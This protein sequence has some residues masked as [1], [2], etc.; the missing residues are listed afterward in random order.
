MLDGL[1]ARLVE[2]GLHA[3][4]LR[5]EESDAREPGAWLDLEVDGTSRR[6][7]VE[8]KSRW[9]RDLDAHLDRMVDDETVAPWI[10]VLPRLDATR[11]A[12]LRERGINHADTTGVIYLRLPGLFIHVDGG[13]RRHWGTFASQKRAV[14]P[15]SKK[16]S[17]V[18]RRF[19]ESPDDSHSVT[20]L[21]RETGI[22]IGWAWDVTE[23]L[24]QRGYIVGTGEHL[25]LADA[26]SALV[27]WCNAYSWTKSKRRSF[28][29]PHLSHEFEE[30][31][32]SAWAPSSLQWALTLLS[33]A[34]RRVGHVINDTVT[35]LYAL[36][37][38]PAELERLLSLVH[39]REITEP[40]PG[41][42]TLR[43][44][45]PYYG[46]AALFGMSMRD[47]LPVLSDLQLF[48]DLAHYPLR[49]VETAVHLLRTRLGPDVGMTPADIARIER[50]IS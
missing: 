6:L 23:E 24:S 10:L 20:S 5:P 28:V 36:P 44:L 15:F 32:A 46:Q 2:N 4:V 40:V 34:Q 45:E 38:G 37:S 9:T 11:R 26:A 47:D 1:A 30:C 14:N 42:H 18:L 17:L 35:S 16:A 41:T 21:A 43:V 39:A 31:R 25:R 12:W 48:L 22:A 8:L 7:H 50:G 49:G 27:H 33:G 3:R 19:F 29:V 13:S